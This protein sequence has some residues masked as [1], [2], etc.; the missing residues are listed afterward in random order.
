MILIDMDFPKEKEILIRIDEKGEV[1]VYGSYPAELHH[2]V[3]VLPHSDLID[4]DAL[5]KYE[6]PALLFPNGRWRSP[7]V[8]TH[9]V[10]I[11]NIQEAPTVIPATESNK[12]NVLDA[13]GEDGNMTNEEKIKSK[14]TFDLAMFLCHI[15]RCPPQKHKPSCI[16]NCVACWND[17]LQSDASAEEET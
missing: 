9:A 3:E 16:N 13:L 11:G 1:Y 10:A 2:A 15:P 6:L 8:W 7:E 14:K 5:L 12:S 17:W 4:R